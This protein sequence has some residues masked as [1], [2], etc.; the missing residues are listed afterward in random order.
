VGYGPHEV[1]NL[2]RMAP[3]APFVSVA[4][5]FLPAL[6]MMGLAWSG[7]PALFAAGLGVALMAVLTGAMTED[8][9]AD[10]ADGLFGGSTVERRLEI[11][12]DSRHGTYGVSALGLYLI[13]RVAAFGALASVNPLE[14]GAIMVASSVVAR[15]GS[16][17]LS[18]DLPLAREGGA[19]S[20]AGRVGK[21]A[22]TAGAAFAAIL[23]FVLA[24]PFAGLL[25]VG[26]SLLAAAGVALGWVW[27][28][29]RL[30]GGQSGDLIGA[31][32]ALIEIAVLTVLMI[33]T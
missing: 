11:M 15:S 23:L 18:A 28:C 9:L 1:P 24:G 2:D 3:A 4:I 8:A 14:A 19:A 12:K 27:L 22:F 33:F 31:L 5:A 26:F 21:T 29:R 25:G 10:A 30:I 13:L 7:V 6:V 16:L 32:H 17:W 20:S